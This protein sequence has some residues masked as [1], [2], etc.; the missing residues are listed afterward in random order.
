MES[1]QRN[2]KQNPRFLAVGIKKKRTRKFQEELGDNNLGKLLHNIVYGVLDSPAG[3]WCMSLTL[4]S[5][6]QTLTWKT[7]LTT[8]QVPE[9]PGAEH[10]Q[11]HLNCPAKAL[12][13]E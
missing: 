8:A 9:Q 5:I 10:K 13:T 7:G 12:K 4:T 1:V 6:P 2:D 11:N 3:F